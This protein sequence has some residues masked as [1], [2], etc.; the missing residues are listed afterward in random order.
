MRQIEREVGTKRAL[1][2]VFFVCSEVG[3]QTDQ[4]NS[5]DPPSVNIDVR[6][7]EWGETSD[8]PETAEVWNTLSVCGTWQVS[9]APHHGLH[10]MV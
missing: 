4:Q 1:H 10:T 3:R 5:F 6:F 9:K 2:S 7:V 8:S